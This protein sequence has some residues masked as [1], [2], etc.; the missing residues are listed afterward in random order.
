MLDRIVNYAALR[1]SES[2][3]FNHT[4]LVLYH[5][6]WCVATYIF[7]IT[8]RQAPKYTLVRRQ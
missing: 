8:A 6:G 7:K 4:F 1:V 5:P 2:I 3:M